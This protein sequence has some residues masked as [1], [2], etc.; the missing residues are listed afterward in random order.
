[1]KI[2]KRVCF[3]FCLLKSKIILRDKIENP[4]SPILIRYKYEETKGVSLVS[5][6]FGFLKP[7][8]Y[9]KEINVKKLEIEI[10][11]KKRNYEISQV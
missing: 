9:L 4:S 10:S 7:N 5:F 3:R 6:F 11:K 2:L 8:F 1:L